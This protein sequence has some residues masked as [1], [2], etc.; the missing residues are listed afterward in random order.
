MKNKSKPIL[1]FAFCLSTGMLVAQESANG[2]GGEATGSGGTVSYSVGQVA[3]TN[4]TGSNGNI[5]QGVQ[6]PYEIYTV[7]IDEEFSNLELTIYPNPAADIL[8]IE[9]EE[10]AD[11]DAI[12]QL[13]DASGKTLQE[14]TIQSNQSTLE[15]SS[16]QAGTYML[17]ITAESVNI[18][19][20]K[21]IKH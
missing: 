20:F 6:Q 10:Y 8:Q 3:Y 13:I 1:L 11:Y 5:N 15:M 18:K 7:V 17:N 21:I 19:T 4:H 16:Y 14:S 2:S 9:F 12:Y